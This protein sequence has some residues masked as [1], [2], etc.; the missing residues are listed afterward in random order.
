MIVR[1]IFLNACRLV[2]TVHQI[3]VV[4]RYAHQSHPD[5]HVLSRGRVA[6]QASSQ[7]MTEE[8]LQRV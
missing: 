4:W 5:M 2:C 6:I 1:N 8:T 7:Q 3:T